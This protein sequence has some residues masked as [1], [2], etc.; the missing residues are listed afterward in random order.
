[1]VARLPVGPALSSHDWIS[2]PGLA[3]QNRA[4]LVSSSPIQSGF[5]THPG[6]LLVRLQPGKDR[7]AVFAL[8]LIYI[9][10]TP[11]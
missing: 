5:A 10:I 2:A 11:S 4:S 7:T 9:S 3:L 1:M 6:S 8:A